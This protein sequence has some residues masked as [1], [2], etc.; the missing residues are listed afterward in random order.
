MSKFQNTFKFEMTELLEM[1]GQSVELLGSK[2]LYKNNL[3]FSPSKTRTFRPSGENWL[4][5]WKKINDLGVW[6]WE[7]N[8][9]NP[10]LDGT[11]WSLSIEHED[12]SISSTGGNAYPGVKGTSYGKVFP[13]FLQAIENL[14]GEELFLIAPYMPKLSQKDHAQSVVFKYFVPVFRYKVQDGQ[15]INEEVLDEEL[16]QSDGV[17]YARTDKKTIAY[18]G[19]TNGTLKSRVKDH[20]RRIPKIFKAK[21]PRLYFL[22]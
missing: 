1:G 9:H 6:G 2:V 4:L 21:G 18:I 22:G 10:C 19:K 3:S 7:E 11:C 5:F 8:Y 17:V 12:K 20:L 14:V 16:W 13:N 15:P